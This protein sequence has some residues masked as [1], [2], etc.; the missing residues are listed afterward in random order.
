MIQVIFRQLWNQRRQNGWIFVELLAVSFFLWTVID[1]IYVLTANRHIDPGYDARGRYVVQMATYGKGNSHYRP[2]FASDSLSKETYRRILRTLRQLPEVES[3]CLT[4]SY[5]FPNCNSWDGIQVFPD[6]ASTNQEDG[7]KHGQSY[8]FVLT[9]GS[10][11][12]HTFGFKDARTG[13]ELHLP[14]DIRNRVFL[15]ERLASQLFGSTDVV[16]QKVYRYDKSAHE[17]AGVFRNYKHRDY[18]QPYPLHI[19]LQDTLCGGSWMTYQY[20]PVLRLKEGVDPEAFEQ[21]FRTE[22]MP[23]LTAGNF[24]CK[25]LQTFHEL[26]DLFVAASGVTNKLRLQYSLTGFTILCIFLGMVGTFWI[27]CNARRQEIGVMCSMGASRGTISRQFLTEAWLLVT[28]AFV[29]MLPLL[30][31]HARIDGM[32]EVEMPSNYFVPDPR[33][34]QNRFG[35]HFCIVS[36]LA[37][38]VQLAVALVGTYIPVKRATRILPAEALRDE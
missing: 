21:R 12:F 10:D 37:Y 18:Q 24:Y 28:L 32:Y 8:E 9:E 1:P 35:T 3:Y 5:S 15:S 19:A 33:Y 36:L 29:V 38:V 4:T 16:G 23:Q 30:W 11:P 13:G 2:E 26:S 6:T 25:Q 31:H 14:G 22:V 7:F 20:T 34:A 17:V 27:R